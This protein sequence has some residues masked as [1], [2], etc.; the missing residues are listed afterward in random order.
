[1][2]LR[3]TSGFAQIATPLSP[4]VRSSEI[5]SHCHDADIVKGLKNF[6]LH[7]KAEMDVYDEDPQIYKF[8][9]LVIGE[10]NA[11]KT[12]FVTRYIHDTFSPERHS[13]KGVDYAN[14]TFDWDPSTRVILHFW[15]VAGQE[16]IGTQSSV[17]F[18]G[19]HAA[20]I[21]YDVTEEKSFAAVPLWKQLVDENVTRNGVSGEIPCILLA[22]KIDLITTKSEEFDPTALK[23]MTK[24]CKF[25]CGIPISACGNYNVVQSVKKLVELLL[26]RQRTQEAEEKLLGAED[27][28]GTVKILDGN[29]PVASRCGR[30]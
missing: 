17:Y 29:L 2:E 6:P 22:N 19:A 28:I 11:G 25:D 1:M 18:R 27:E 8:K 20:L 4:L 26:N 14:Y 23:D 21:V 9:V 13:T 10:P 7:H 3:V 12:A 5:K 24:T 16:R 30:C 15:D